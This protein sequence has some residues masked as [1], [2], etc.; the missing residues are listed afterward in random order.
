MAD[1]TDTTD[2]GS[3]DWLIEDMRERYLEDPDSVSES[4]KA[5]FEGS[6]QEESGQ[7]SVVSGQVV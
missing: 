3:N 7:G 5:F 2:V 4:W 6:D 1:H